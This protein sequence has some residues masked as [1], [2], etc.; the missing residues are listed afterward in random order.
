M[1]RMFVAAVAILAM[2]SS[3]VAADR[4]TIVGPNG[5]YPALTGKKL[6]DIVKQALELLPRDLR[7]KTEDVVVVTNLQAFLAAYN[8]GTDEAFGKSPM[9]AISGEPRVFVLMDKSLPKSDPRSWVL[10]LESEWIRYKLTGQ[11]DPGMLSVV[12]VGLAHEK[13]HTDG[14]DE[15][16]A[17]VA[18]LEFIQTLVRQGRLNPE[19]AGDF[20]QRIRQDLTVLSASKQQ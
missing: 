9:C 20:K 14:A 3:A 11:T 6:P 13:A 8:Q 19:L 4:I 1:K 15:E 18:T 2:A 10:N 7:I 17:H 16:S 5:E 12:A